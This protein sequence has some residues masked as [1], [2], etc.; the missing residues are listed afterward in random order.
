MDIQVM[1]TLPVPRCFVAL[2]PHST[3]PYR[4]AISTQEMT[5]SATTR[6]WSLA[7]IPSSDNAVS[8]N[9]PFASLQQNQSASARAFLPCRTTGRYAPPSITAPKHKVDARLFVFAMLEARKRRPFPTN[10]R[11]WRSASQIAHD[12]FFHPRRWRTRRVWA[13]REREALGELVGDR[14]RGRGA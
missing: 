8:T 2:S 7:S 1:R 9:T 3:L 14:G 13:G 11:T 6:R 12:E 4:K 5:I 10:E